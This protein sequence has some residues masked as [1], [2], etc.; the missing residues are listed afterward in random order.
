MTA[1]VGS[2]SD[3]NS[4]MNGLEAIVGESGPIVTLREQVR[5]LLDRERTMHRLPPVLIIGETGTG[6]GLLA[7]VIHRASSRSSAEFVE[8]SC[9]AIPDTLIESELFGYESG[10]FTDARKS[11]PGLLQTAHGGTLFLDEIGLL[12][13]AIQAKLL[14]V[15]EDT[16][17]R[18]LGATRSETVNVA[19]ISATNEDLGAAVREQRFREDLYHR[20][21]VIVLSLPPLRQRGADVEI[22]ATHALTQICTEY[23]LRPKRLAPDARDALR[24]HSWPGNVRELKNALKRAAFLSDERVISAEMLEFEPVSRPVSSHPASS[25]QVELPVSD[26]ELL[27]E[28]LTRTEWNISRTAGV[29]G[30]TRNTVRAR[31][32]K[33][34]FRPP[35][36]TREQGDDAL[37]E[38]VPVHVAAPAPAVD[39]VAGRPSIAA[40]PLRVEGDDAGQ[41]YFGDGVVE[42]VV[43][44]LAALRELFVISRSSTLR[45]RGIDVDVRDVGRELGVAYVLSG[46]VRRAGAR[47]RLRVELAETRRGTVLWAQRFDGADDQIFALQDEIT[48]RVVNMLAPQVRELELRRSLRRRPENLLA[49]DCLLRGQS[50][51]Y[52][53]DIEEFTRARTWLQKAIEMD[54]TYAAPYALLAIWH[55]LRAQQGWS[56][57]PAA[58][59]AEVDRLAAAAVERD[60]FDPVALALSGHARSIL[61]HEFDEALALFERAL[62]AGPSCAIA[63][64]RS[65][66]TYSYIGKLD[67]AIRRAEHGLRL[68]PLDP[69]NFY[70]HGILGLAHYLGSNY[71]EAARWGRKAHEVSPRYTANL[72]IFAASLAGGGEL[73]EARA[74]GSA[75]L[76]VAPGFSAKRFVDGYAIQDPE[77]RARLLF[78]LRLAGLPE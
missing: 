5:S 34:G 75:L 42:D 25:H 73:D 21:A 4:A 27:R 53:L 72:R 65:S 47:L 41:A 60:G 14:R 45:Y 49:Y 3:Y 15:L 26:R 43:G 50:Q 69:H 62:A 38:S 13:F 8:M 11:K 54:P 33:Y 23:G 2:A 36:G 44:A 17:V 48:G 37:V 55:S 56:P 67:E 39:A 66:P 29:L 74:I 46:S 61:R 58:D 52:Q 57:D 16:Q 70:V 19:F 51:L 64:V 59:H 9:A 31:I 12:P 63:W 77:Q 10:A 68:S 76:K 40:L 30:I 1:I 32:A 18:R 6:K 22:L 71:A 7:S 78:H 35:A 20:L 24:A 28:T